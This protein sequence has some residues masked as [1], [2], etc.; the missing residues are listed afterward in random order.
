MTLTHR[1]DRAAT[2]LLLILPGLASAQRGVAR[3]VAPPRTDVAQPA[4]PMGSTWGTRISPR[5]PPMPRGVWGSAERATIGRTYHSPVSPPRPVMTGRY[6]ARAKCAGGSCRCF[7][8]TGCNRTFVS[9]TPFG[10]PF[11][12]PY[13]VPVAVPYAESYPVFT[14]APP[15]SLRGAS[16]PVVPVKPSGPGHL[17]MV[18]IDS[19][20]DPGSGRVTI[21]HVSDSLLRLTWLPGRLPI[22]E[23]RL[24]VADS[25]QRPLRTRRVDAGTPGALVEIHD[26]VG[27]IAY[28]GVAVVMKHGTIL[29]TLVPYRAGTRPGRPSPPR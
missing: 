3:T 17:T 13:D 21:E 10:V 26:L 27:R 19:T 23:A 1:L 7:G 22:S 20:G 16:E 12:V 4:P 25:S 8:S 5:N 9:V 15:Y 14:Y 29:T 6:W 24:F 18:V 11:F 28:T 2:I